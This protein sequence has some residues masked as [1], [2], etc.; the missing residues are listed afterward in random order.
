MSEKD[1]LIEH[2]YDGIQEYDNPMPRWWVLTFWATIVFSVM[3]TFDV[4]F[5][6][7]EGRVAQYAADMAAWRE[8]HPAGGAPVDTAALLAMAANA[9]AVHEG[10]ETFAKYCAACHAADGGGLI[11][12]NLTD[13]SWLHGGR[14]DEIHAVIA[15][16]VL[17]KGMPAWAKQLKPEEVDQVTAYVWSLYGSTPAQPKAPEGLVVTR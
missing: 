13:S 9:D 10:G 16:G 8:A 12:P 1:R 3:Y 4:G 2:S 14:I 15:N 6:T 5:G 11:G 17:A 7:G